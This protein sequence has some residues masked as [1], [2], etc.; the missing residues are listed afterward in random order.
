MFLGVLDGWIARVSEADMLLLW[1]LS[2]SW[3]WGIISYRCYAPSLVVF[4]SRLAGYFGCAK[5]LG[6]VSQEGKLLGEQGH[7]SI[8]ICIC[9]VC[10]RRTR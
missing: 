1:S 5:G 6:A 10:I 8:G 7:T 3:V 9:C 4:V 2:G